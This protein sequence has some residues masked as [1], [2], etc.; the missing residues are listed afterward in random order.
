MKRIVG[1][2]SDMCTKTSWRTQCGHGQ[3]QIW[4]DRSCRQLVSTS[5]CG[6]PG[7]AKSVPGLQSHRTYVGKARTTSQRSLSLQCQP[8]IRSTLSCLEEY[9]DDG[10]SDAPGFDAT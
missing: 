7:M 2:M 9:P 4:A 1:T 5:P 6:S 3:E 10:G 8:E